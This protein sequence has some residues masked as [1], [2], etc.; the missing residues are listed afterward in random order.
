[1]WMAAGWLGK[2]KDIC[3]PSVVVVF[4]VFVLGW[5]T[6][7]MQLNEL[8][9][10][11]DAL[12]SEIDKLRPL[13]PEVEHRIMRKFRL[14]W[15]Y[16]S[17]AIE[18]NSLTLGET[19]AFLLEGLTANGKPMKDHLDIKGH[20]ELITFLE[21][22]IQRREVLSEAAIREM[23]RILLKEPY[24]TEAITPDGRTIKKHVRLGEYKI[25][26][27]SV[28][29]KSG[30]IYQYV[31]PQDVPAKMADL[32]AWHRQID[33]KKDIHP[34]AHA[35]LLHHLFVS[36]HP[37][38][39]GN[40]RMARILMNLVLMRSG[41]PPVVIKLQERQPYIAALRQADVGEND[42]LFA[43]IGKNLLD[44]ENL[45]LRGARNEPI[46][47]ADDIDKAVQLLKQELARMEEPQELSITTLGE[48]FGSSIAV[49][50]TRSANKLTQFDELFYRETV[51]LSREIYLDGEL[52][53]WTSGNSFQ[54]SKKEIIN[55]VSQAAKNWI[56]QL[57]VYFGWEGFRKA[58]LHD[59]N[60]GVQLRFEFEKRKYVIACQSINFQRQFMYQQ[61][62]SDDEVREFVSKV[63]KYCLDE[64][65]RN[66]KAAG[67]V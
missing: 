45:Y 65:E 43:F 17:N 59:F 24:E 15:N 10:Q 48:L 53:G 49:I 42:A 67:L 41:L 38:D 46:E 6:L 35:A 28:R 4:A 32:I 51:N 62:M 12:K 66:R 31:L 8:F 25:E 1:M 14:D 27:N 54:G 34:V 5:Y 2:R 18:G 61:R 20:D 9:A 64:I 16:H 29:M 13:K 40:G 44:S 3:A 56:R 19:R 37:F 23:H 26:P 39:D 22:F 60:M 55:L 57:T 11:V 36:I 7:A 52:N 47:D 58:G 21:L 50:V 63:A 33:E 30:E